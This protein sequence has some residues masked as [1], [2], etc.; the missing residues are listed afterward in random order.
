MQ[1]SRGLLVLEML[2]QYFPHLRSCLLKEES[3]IRLGDALTFIVE[4]DMGITAFWTYLIGLQS[5]G[6]FFLQIDGQGVTPLALPTSL[7]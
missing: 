5:L 4:K 6:P 7:R 3:L 2:L 1:Q